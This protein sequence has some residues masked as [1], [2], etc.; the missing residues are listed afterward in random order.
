MFV[1]NRNN[2]SYTTSKQF[3]LYPFDQQREE[4]IHHQAFMTSE[5]GKPITRE[6]SYASGA[7]IHSVDSSN[8]DKPLS[9][10][11]LRLRRYRYI[12]AEIQSLKHQIRR[13]KAREQDIAERI[14]SAHLDRLPG[15]KGQHDDP[16][17]ADVE[18][19]I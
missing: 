19:M 15:G 7:H 8:A 14:P 6:R 3:V 4:N 1:D 17:A 13:L 9:Q 12:S 5:G 16:T 2:R 18:D 10:L 11:L